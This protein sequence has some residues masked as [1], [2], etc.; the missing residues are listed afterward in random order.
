MSLTLALL[1][2]AAPP[3]AAEPRLPAF[4][5][6]QAGTAG[7]GEGRPGHEGDGERGPTCWGGWSQHLLSR[8]TEGPL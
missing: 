4:A 7:C 8:E 5:E 6:S 3:K 2:A 1:Q